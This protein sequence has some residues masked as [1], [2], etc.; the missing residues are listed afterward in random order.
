MNAVLD[1]PRATGETA[2]AR[3]SQLLGAGEIEK[4]HT[5]TYLVVGRQQRRVL[6]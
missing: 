4:C 1:R 2:D 5:E 3:P 6:T